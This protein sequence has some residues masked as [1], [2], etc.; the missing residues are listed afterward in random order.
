M[1]IFSKISISEIKLLISS[2]KANYTYKCQE[3]LWDES[4]TAALR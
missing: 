2:F 3:K 1:K 4:V